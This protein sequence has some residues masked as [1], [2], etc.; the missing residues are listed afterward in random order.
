MILPVK[1]KF[2]KGLGGQWSAHA[3]VL[4]ICTTGHD[5]L[6][7]ALEE[8]QDAI[9]R[10]F[11]IEYQPQSPISGNL[12]SIQGSAVV[13]LLSKEEGDLC[14]FDIRFDNEDEEEAMD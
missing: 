4:G 5:S 7:S 9:V 14:E 3:L 13:M 1:I 2:E 10:A 8:V 11:E 6:E 12:G